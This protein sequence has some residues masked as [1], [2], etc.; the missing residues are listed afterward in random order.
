MC[1]DTLCHWIIKK[2]KTS[3]SYLFYIHTHLHIAY[4]RYEIPLT[5][6]KQGIAKKVKKVS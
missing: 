6:G 5:T 2:I 1:M 3:G 4:I